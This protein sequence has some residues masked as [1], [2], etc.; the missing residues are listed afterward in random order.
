MTDSSACASQGG[1]NFALYTHSAAA[2]TLVIFNQQDLFAGRTTAEIPLDPNTNRT[3]DVWHITIPQL[4][5]D[6]LYGT[7]LMQLCYISCL[8][9]PQL[10]LKSIATVSSRVSAGLLSSSSPAGQVFMSLSRQEG[11]SG[12]ACAGFRVA[13]ANQESHNSPQSV[14]LRHDATKVLLD[15]YATSVVSRPRW[16]ERGNPHLD[17]KDPTVLGFA[18]TWPQ[19]ASPLPDP[20]EAPFDWQ[21]C[22]H[23][24][25]MHARPM[26][27]RPMH[28]PCTHS[29][30]DNVQRP[31]RL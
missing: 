23:A 7:F 15:P 3:G 24:R 13:G 10:P 29:G 14:G 27:S 22:L 11:D 12:K 26:H 4:P 1:H 5:S 19:A 31:A 9:L 20:D 25:P 30:C 21:V 6:L 28:A 17:Y 2:V 8:Y 18:D 16:G